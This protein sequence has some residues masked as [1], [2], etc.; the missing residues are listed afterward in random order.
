MLLL[1]S[2]GAAQTSD[3]L[4]PLASKVVVST[5]NGN[6]SMTDIGSEFI[7]E[8]AQTCAQSQTQF[9][10]G[11]V[12][13]VDGGE[14]MYASATPYN[15]YEYTSCQCAQNAT[16]TRTMG[17][18]TIGDDAL[19]RWTWKLYARNADCS[20]TLK[21]DLV[22]L[23][24]SYENSTCGD[25]PE[26]YT[27]SAL[28]LSECVPLSPIAIDLDGDGLRLSNR[29]GGVEFDLNGD[30]VQGQVPWLQEDGWLV[31]DDRE[32][33]VVSDG[34]QLFGDQSAQDGPRAG[35]SPNGYAALRIFDDNKDER[36]D[37]RDGVWRLLG[38]W[39]DFNH[40]GVSDSGE[41]QS[42]SAVGIAAL[43]LDYK[44]SQRI[45]R[46]GNRLRYRARVEWTSGRHTSSWDVFLTGK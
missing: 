12:R 19:V 10:N 9:A 14:G 5:V 4:L 44:L 2:T 42:L 30:R 15:G 20:L 34:G 3:G 38:I 26:G 25:C 11:E 18:V 8:R 41:V 16:W 24:C 22:A 29:V 6:C 46:Y 17:N 31:L 28:K 40:N 36:I 7:N 13:L 35:E 32:D 37:R 33:G 43:S 27:C 45:D 39:R 23:G 1:V 21:R